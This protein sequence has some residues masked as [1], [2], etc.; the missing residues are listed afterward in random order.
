[1]EE[2]MSTTWK[3]DF[4]AAYAFYRAEV[5][6]IQ[7]FISVAK[8]PKSAAALT[9]RLASYKNFIKFLFEGDDEYPG[10]YTNPLSMQKQLTFDQYIKFIVSGRVS[11]QLICETLQRMENYNKPKYF[12]KERKY[13]GL[14]L[15]DWK[16][17]QGPGHLSDTT[18]SAAAAPKRVNQ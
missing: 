5:D 3:E 7:L 9:Q 10:P 16:N 2:W 1:M 11:K 4:P 12:S 6:K 18:G 17:R 13:L 8:D 15:K 14:T